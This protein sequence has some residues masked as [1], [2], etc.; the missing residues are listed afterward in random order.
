MLADTRNSQYAKLVP[1]Q[2]D[3][4]KWTAGIWADIMDVFSTKTII[5]IQNMFEDQEISHIIENF[6]IC[7]NKLDMRSHKGPHFGDG[8]F[9]KWFEAALYAGKYM[10]NESLLKQLDGYVKLIAQSQLPDGYISTK[11]IL[12]ERSGLKNRME[13]INAFEIYNMG[14][15]IT[16]AC[17]HYRLTGK[18]NC[19]KREKRQRIILRKFM[20]NLL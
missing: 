15:L 3:A 2:W 18:K 17:M 14:H 7:A 8:D 1:L 19:W 12:K 11:Q 9:Y 20:I 5:H 16:L 6:R 4:V 13:K 10:S